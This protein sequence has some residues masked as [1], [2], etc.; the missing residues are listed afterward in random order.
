MIKPISAV[1]LV[2][3]AALSFNTQAKVEPGVYIG[4]DLNTSLM[5]TQKE[6]KVFN[7]IET[8][9]EGSISANSAGFSLGYRF[10]TNNRFQ[11][12]RTYINVEFDD[13][14]KDTFSGT[15]F[16][17]HF[18]YGKEQ[19]QIYWGLGFGLYMYEDTARLLTEKDDLEGISLQLLGGLK[20]N[21]HEHVELDVSYRA[22]TI[23]WQ[24]MT[25]NEGLVS[26]TRD[27][28]HSFASVNLGA[29]IKF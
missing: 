1:T 13:D 6:R 12:S 23:A 22:K 16:D 26:I 24:T 8:K 15:D 17:W 9:E 4:L 21:V 27:L 18:V 2:S 5:S 14:K 29:A 3:L 20:I 19:V 7:G 11:I 25:Y 10:A 28:S